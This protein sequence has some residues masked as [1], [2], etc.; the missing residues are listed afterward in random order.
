MPPRARRATEPVDLLADLRE[1]D[2]SLLTDPAGPE[3]VDVPAGPGPTVDTVAAAVGRM[4][5][6][7]TAAALLHKGGICG[8]RHIVRLVL[9]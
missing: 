3:H 2:T 5:A 1:P 8:C 9:G 4:H 7:P 6:D